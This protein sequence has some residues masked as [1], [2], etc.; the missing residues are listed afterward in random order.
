MLIRWKHTEFGAILKV[1]AIHVYWLGKVQGR[2]KQVRNV[3]NQCASLTTKD[4]QILDGMRL[5]HSS[6]QIF[7]I[8]FTAKGGS[9]GHD[10]G[11]NRKVF[12]LD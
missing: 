5:L 12:V 9:S 3:V 8:K 10:P 6:L 7:Y 11:S 4:L 2:Q 1:L